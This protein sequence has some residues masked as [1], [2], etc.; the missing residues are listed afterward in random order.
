MPF[1]IKPAPEILQR[2]LEEALEGLPGVKN[3]H[4]DVIMY[5]EGKKKKKEKRG[6]KRS[7]IMM[8]GWKLYCSDVKS[9]TLF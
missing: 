2:R 3:I 4:D 5:G 7:V 9:S 8:R 1:G 6:Q